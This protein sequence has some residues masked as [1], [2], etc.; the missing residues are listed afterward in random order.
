MKIG[1]ENGNQ[2]QE[3]SHQVPELNAPW[4]R[5]TFLLLMGL[6]T[7]WLLI[8]SPPGSLTD[9]EAPLKLRSDWVLHCSVYCS[10]T[11]FFI[12]S[13]SARYRYWGVGFSLLHALGTET[14]QIYIPSRHFDPADL[15]ANGCGLLLGMI[16]WIVYRYFLISSWQI[17]QFRNEVRSC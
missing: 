17:L 9:F 13:Q 16:I 5:I 4:A 14:L 7:Y 2:A 8:P 15:L 1:T 10:V 12:S 6:I 3:P 11:F